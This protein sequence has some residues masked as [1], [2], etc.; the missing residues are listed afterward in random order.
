MILSRK[1][2][3]VFISTPKTGSHS[4]FK[5]L[6]E[7]F[8]G[9]R[10]GPQFHRT[11]LPKA[12]D[13]YTV[14]STCRNPYERLVALW[15]SLLFSKNDKHAY[16]DTWLRVIKK[17]DFGTFCKFA[18]ENTHNIETLPALRLPILM[19]PQYRWYRRLPP[20]VLPLH[21]E[22]IN[23]EF[24]ALS[25]VDREVEIPRVLH[26]PHANWDELKTDEIIHHA[27][28]WAGEDFEKFGY[29]KET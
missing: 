10:L 12:V 27:N 22:N 5:L 9:E 19:M 1:N 6:T 14:F 3:Y 21:L 13:G 11:E 29:S 2:K 17:D 20:N 16:R 7:E 28:I 18:A 25:F 15:N 4:F 23:E 8:D 24:N 26:R